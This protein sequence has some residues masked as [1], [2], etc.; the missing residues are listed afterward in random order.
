[1]FDNALGNENHFK[2]K[3]VLEKMEFKNFNNQKSQTVFET[4][5]AFKRAYFRRQNL[6]KPAYTKKFN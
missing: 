6:K 4:I 1:L 5:Y 3:R 2:S